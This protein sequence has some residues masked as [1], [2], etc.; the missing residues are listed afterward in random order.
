MTRHNLHTQRAKILDWLQSRGPLST[1]Q[2]R[3]E[4]DILHPAARVQEL[5][6]QG[7]NIITYRENI[8]GHRKVAKYV[9][10]AEGVMQ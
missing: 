10:L 6:E 8:E 9:L 2:S 5:R 3:K 7:L 1:I 4:L